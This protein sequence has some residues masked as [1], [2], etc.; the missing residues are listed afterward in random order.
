MEAFRHADPQRS[1]F[2]SPPSS[3]A[4]AQGFLS[5]RHVRSAERGGEGWGD[6]GKEDLCLFLRA[7]FFFDL[8]F[9]IWTQ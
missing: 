9:A 3:H 4:Q 5:V 7:R 1:L 8:W 6:M 2:P